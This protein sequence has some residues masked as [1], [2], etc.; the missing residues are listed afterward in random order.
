MDFSWVNVNTKRGYIGIT[1]FTFIS[2]HFYENLV[3]RNDVD[4]VMVSD[5]KGRA[6]GK[7]R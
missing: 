3:Q 4:N 6:H 2:R 1:K 7:A 5:R